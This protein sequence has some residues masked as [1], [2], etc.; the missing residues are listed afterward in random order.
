MENTKYHEEVIYLKPGDI[1]YLYTD[2]ITEAMNKKN[3]L[4]G[5]PRLLD[6][7][8][9]YESLPPAEFAGA[10]KKEVDQHS[11][12]VDQADDIT[13]LILK[14]KNG[15]YYNDI[16]R[17]IMIIADSSNLD[18][19]INFVKSELEKWAC[20]G[21]FINEICIAV[22]EIFM[23]IVNYAYG[24]DKGE[25]KINIFKHT[26]KPV[27]TAEN[28]GE[29][30]EIIQEITIRFEDK[31]L[32]YNPLEQSDPDLKSSISERKIGGLGIFM[33]KKLMDNVEYSRFDEKNILV[34]KKRYPQV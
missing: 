32:P 15:N 8:N 5:E 20:P 1:L 24:K 33:F 11:Q 10:I 13:M 17:E 4:F 28:T 6:T 25:V 26:D 22:E 23:N 27:F 16:S 14:I 9:K 3:E 19:T 2:G 12:G 18:F 29:N 31:G 34:V 21:G 7:V 30:N